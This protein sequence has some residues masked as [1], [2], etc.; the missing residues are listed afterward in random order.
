MLFFYVFEF[1]ISDNEKDESENPIEEEPEETPQTFKELVNLLCFYEI[2]QGV[3]E[4]LVE[5]CERLNW[6]MPS[7]IQ[8]KAIPAALEG[9]DIIGLAETG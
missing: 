1:K 3:C 8:S 4:P 5:A 9:R 2:F 6:K 7:K